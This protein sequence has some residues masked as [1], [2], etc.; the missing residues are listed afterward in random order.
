MSP[1]QLLRG[2]SISNA[3]VRHFIVGPHHSVCFLMK[4]L[5]KCE[6]LSRVPVSEKWNIVAKPSI[7]LCGRPSTLLVW[8]KTCRIVFE[9]MP[10]QA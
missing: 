8:K 7:L 10:K 2:S 4:Q 5:T 9:G 1:I 6:N 3:P